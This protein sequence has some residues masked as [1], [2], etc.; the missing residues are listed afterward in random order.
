LPPWLFDCV[1]TLHHQSARKSDL[2]SHQ[3]A[4]H[5]DDRPLACEHCNYR[6]SRQSA[7]V[8]HKE[9]MH[10]GSKAPSQSQ[11]Q[12]QQQQ[13]A[14]A[15]AAAAAA[16]VAAASAPAVALNSTVAWGRVWNR[17]FVSATELWDAR[18][19]RVTDAGS[20]IFSFLWRAQRAD[21]RRLRSFPVFEKEQTK[22]KSI[23]PSFSHYRSLNHVVEACIHLHEKSAIRD[24]RSRE[25][26]DCNRNGDST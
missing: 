8:R 14:A 11:P 18:R 16:A 15:A 4:K 19:A 23:N 2:L 12:S 10:A 6:A 24:L 1:S 3:R 9:K 25:Q 5:S 7:M 21:M 20:D 17:I 26:G 13:Q 22:N